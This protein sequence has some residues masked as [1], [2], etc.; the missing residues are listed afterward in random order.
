MAHR[1]LDP[2]H[3]PLR[4]AALQA[5]GLLDSPPE[6][7]F[8]RMTA[9]ASDLLGT[10]VALLSLVDD[11]RQFF[12]SAAG[13]GEPWVTIRGT[14]AD[15]SFC[16]H[17]VRRG[18]PFVV[19]DA[20]HD[21]VMAGNPAITKL[22]TVAYAGVPVRSSRGHVLGSFCVTS[23]EP[24]EWTE[25]DLRVLG[26]LAAAVGTEIALRQEVRDRQAALDALAVSEQRLALTLAVTGEG[27]YDTDLHSGSA[28]LSPSLARL[29]GTSETWVSGAI[30]RWS[31]RIHPE[32]RERVQAAFGAHLSGATA[33]VRVQYRMRGAE[34]EWHWL[35]DRGQ[36]VER[37][38]AGRALRIVGL[39]VDVT[40]QVHAADRE[41]QL[42]RERDAPLG[43]LELQRQSMPMA[44]LMA[45]PTGRVTYANPAAEA[46][47]GFPSAELVGRSFFE[48]IVPPEAR[49][50]VHEVV[51][52][53]L[54]D[55]VATHT[56]NPNR[57]RDGRRLTCEW[58]NAPLLDDQG[59]LRSLLCMAHDITE[60]DHAVAALRQSEETHRQLFER[61]PSPLWAFDRETLR[62]LAVNDAAVEHYG[63]SR[64]EFLAMTI[65]DIRPAEDQHQLEESIAERDAAKDPTA[66]RHAGVFRH[67]RKDG[68]VLFVE[69]ESSEI[70]LDGRPARL[71][72]AT[73]IT[74]RQVTEQALAQSQ[75]ELRQ[76][77]KM[78][79]IGQLA[80]GVAHDFN[81]LLT[82]I[83]GNAELLLHELGETGPG[84]EEVV[85][86]RRAVDRAS[87]VTRGL[88]AFSRKQVLQPQVL[89][90]N[91][92]IRGLTRLLQRL[93]GED[94]LLE[95]E[96][97]PAPAVVL[98][99]PAQ[100][101]QVLV[102]LVV[103]ARDAMPAG[104]TITLRTWQ[105]GAEV[106][107]SVI[108][109]GLGMT[110]DVRERMFE[111]FFT[112]KAQGK[113][114]GLGLSTVLGIVT[115][116][117]GRIACDS[118]VGR[119]TTFT[120]AFPRHA[121]GA[122]TAPA[123]VTAQDFAPGSGTVMI[124]EDEA[125]VRRTI[126]RVLERLG[127]AVIEA[128]HAADALRLGAERAW[129]VDAVLTDL[130]MPEMSGQELVAQLRALQPGLPVLVMTGYSDKA[131][132]E[133]VDG[134]LEKPFMAE[135]LARRM[136]EVLEGRRAR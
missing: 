107:T 132:P 89:D 78:E 2:L 75:H 62:F 28:T 112:T 50:H 21:P 16:Q 91:D 49:E 59:R 77:Q 87:F 81:N 18:E 119:G 73:D 98:A 124:V 110:A 66:R 32:D 22:D 65:R 39:V 31:A 99:D 120:I 23:P 13:L 11:H 12:K 97:A 40:S 72:V 126:R 57:T 20:R 70:H 80:G 133:G 45:D 118:T 36:V 53:L 37:D 63:W 111:P 30:D 96:L 4:L 109:T 129:Q 3:D 44:L 6:A 76:A 5:T 125:P 121:A 15:E 94:I 24:R 100:L 115:Q 108:D 43:E 103:N 68:S 67:Y 47:F 41:R 135:V 102:N 25:H 71:V 101:E 79:A 35:L 34:D 9:L 10:P 131:I 19:R 85:E 104:G 17:V 54:T 88:P 82:A 136:R 1:P 42:Q 29:L 8:D 56:I 14:P 134:V 38:A 105:E 123:T 114:T 116:S 33:E 64:E 74:R 60:R 26:D 7:A 83:T 130:V 106:L 61:H 128:R 86:I 48:T 69:I 122:D 127:Y 93:I 46:L 55:R 58:H 52:R 51:S 27:H 90:V 117:G 92:V 84:H 95:A 113:G